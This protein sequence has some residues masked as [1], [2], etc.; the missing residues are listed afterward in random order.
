L[1]GVADVGQLAGR[2]NPIY[3]EG[4][5]LPLAAST[6]RDLGLKDGEVV[7]ATVQSRGGDDLSLLLRG[8]LM[9]VPSALALVPG[10]TLALKVQASPVGAWGLQPLLEP[11]ALAPGAAPA[12]FSRIG[13]LLFR[14]PGLQELTQMFKPGVMQ[15][16]LDIVPQPDLQA[17]W[18]GM[19]LSMAQLTPQ[20][21]SQAVASA[22]GSEVWLA[23]GLPVPADDPKQLIRRLIAALGRSDSDDDSALEGLSQLQ[24]SVDD[25]ESSQVQAVQ[26]QA[27]RELLFS[28]MLPFAD[29]DPVELVFRRAPR[30]G[31]EAPPLTVNVHSRSQS[32]G[33]LWL[34]TQLHGQDRVDLTMWALQ[35]DVAEQARRR[36]SELASQL[37]EA[38]LAM[39]SFLV[40][41]GPRPAQPADWVPSG[42]GMV[43]DISA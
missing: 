34:R 42:R 16:L 26:A 29:A 32:L 24:R 1:I 15:A 11:A 3:L 36:S 10:Q 12:L 31:G 43:V 20:A 7:Q 30:Q 27:Q 5:L 25:L 19:Q 18:R 21:L 35:G 9:D 22:M 33:E 2:A 23:R 14:P 4:K 37:V 41:H 17:Q 40:V 39:Q 28:M 13:N 38:G 8:K 6:A